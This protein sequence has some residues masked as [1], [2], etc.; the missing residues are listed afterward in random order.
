MC[1]ST[2]LLR[3]LVSLNSNRFFL[4]AVIQKK[5]ILVFPPAQQK[6]ARGDKDYFNIRGGNP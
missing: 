3:Q 6:E 2:L 1:S 5:D 4:H